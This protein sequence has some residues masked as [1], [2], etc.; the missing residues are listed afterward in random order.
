MPY[1][2]V[3]LRI[4]EKQQKQALR[5]ARIRL[6]ADSIGKGE[7]VLLHPL[8]ARKVANA[9]NGLNLELSQGEIAAT[10][11][12]HKIPFS[13]TNAGQLS[14]EGIFGDIWDGIKKTGKWLKDSGVGSTIVDSLVPIIATATGNPA[15]AATARQVLKQATGVGIKPKKGKGLY[16]SRGSGLYI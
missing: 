16:V 12:F 6:T 4:T 13:L 3:K 11:S 14:G 9:K 2:Q 1:I 7:I 5:G 15:A 10:A 8:N